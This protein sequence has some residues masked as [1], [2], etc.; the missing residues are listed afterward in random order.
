MPFSFVH[1][2]DVHLDSPLRSLALLNP[3]L[4]ELIG[5]A[6]RLAFERTVE[7]CLDER[8]DALMI[9]GDLYDGDQTSMKTALFLAAQLQRL[10]EAGIRTF[11]VR[12]NH[13]AQSRITREL[14]L[15]EA[16]KVFGGRAETV[17]LDHD[18][19]TMPVAIHGISFARP[20]AP[21]SLIPRFQ[22]PVPDAFNIGLLHTSLAGSAEH[23]DYAPCSVSDVAGT[24][25]DYWCLGHLHKREVYSREPFIVM[26]GMPQ[27][28]DIGEAGPK[29][30]TLVRVADDGAI[31][32]H[33]HTTS[34]AQ[35]ERIQI[36]LAGV[37]DQRA[38]VDRIAA[39]LTDARTAAQSDHLVVRLEMRGDTELAWRLRRDPELVRAEALHRA[40]LIGQTW[41]EKIA[42]EVTAPGDPTIGPIGE[43][44]DTIRSKIAP[45]DS[46]RRSA[47]EV[48]DEIEKALPPAARDVFGDSEEKRNEILDQLIEE[49]C[50]TVLAHL[51]ETRADGAD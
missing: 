9:A 11:I 46:F 43:V 2:A 6:T 41:I 34:V 38:M 25:F 36:D 24:G 37:S 27:G 50:Q 5:D 29:S 13:D 16:V 3:D 49:G 14:T 30:V 20:H 28:R 15:P 23:D 33:P 35:F 47:L 40:E 32:C 26:P 45:S 4:A 39:G 31:D 51:Q 7:L 42:L 19:G 12:G 8:V 18:R 22:S 10:T 48:L 21:E 1:T 44:A 17:E